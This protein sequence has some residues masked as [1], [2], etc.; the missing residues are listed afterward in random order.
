MKQNLVEVACPVDSVPKFLS[1]THS[2]LF[3][4][5]ALNEFLH[6]FMM[7]HRIDS[8]SKINN[9][10][11]QGCNHSNE[12]NTMERIQMMMLC[13]WHWYFYHHCWPHEGVNTLTLTPVGQSPPRWQIDLMWTSTFGGVW[14]AMLI[15]LLRSFRNE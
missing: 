3:G 15:N 13:W 1:S 11:Q 2:K 8:T 6:H 9:C 10:L 14:T 12:Q 5:A 7:F 4:I